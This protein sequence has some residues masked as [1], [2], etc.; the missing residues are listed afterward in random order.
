MNDL[1]SQGSQSW[2]GRKPVQCELIISKIGKENNLASVEVPGY[3][4]RR[5][6]FPVLHPLLR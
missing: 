2:K 1:R 6:K 4:N 3:R 5:H